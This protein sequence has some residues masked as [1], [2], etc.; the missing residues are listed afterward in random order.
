MIFRCSNCNGA[1]TYDI[2][3]GKM[4][5]KNC[6]SVFDIDKIKR[7]HAEENMME[8][9]VFVC[10]SCAAKLVVNQVESATFCAYCGQPTIVFERVSK[11]L[12]PDKI[13]PFKL[14]KEE[15][16]KK[17]R[18][19]FKKGFFIPN[20]I[21][22]FKV[23]HINAIYVPFFIYDINYRDS[24][25]LR[26]KV[27]KHWHNFYRNDIVDFKGM[28]IDASVNL[29]NDSS[30]RL[31]LFELKELIN[32]DEAY[33][34]GFYAD[35]YDEKKKDLEKRVFERCKMLY[36][37]ESEY[38]VSASNV[39]IETSNPKYKIKKKIYALLPAWFMT[40][41]YKEKPYT[42]LV[43]GQTGKVVGAV[44][45][46]KYK[47]VLVFFV[48]FAIFIS[49]IPDLFMKWFVN[50]SLKEDAF[51]EFIFYMIIYGMIS[52]FT[53][54]C[55]ETCYKSIKKH[56]NNTSDEILKNYNKKRQESKN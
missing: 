9:N 56:I 51:E 52:L 1:L 29:C 18:K 14:T 13:I 47:I 40:I 55:G 30:E 2:E 8:A 39:S 6:E 23:E 38:R 15:A 48:L 31:E 11:F 36:N 35:C 22:K 43:N 3:I 26:G 32:F 41:R 53:F 54:F 12:K 21:K 5:C 42:I 17:I 25:T 34:S 50:V 10:T 7:N 28:T 27:G 45:F 24:Q 37:R 33:L 49:F 4:K 44:P 19:R 46:V 16:I 20:K